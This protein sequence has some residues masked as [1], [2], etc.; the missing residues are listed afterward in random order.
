MACPYGVSAPA[1]LPETMASSL[2]P[3]VRDKF[4]ELWRDVEEGDAKDPY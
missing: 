1:R 4:L 2:D 3:W